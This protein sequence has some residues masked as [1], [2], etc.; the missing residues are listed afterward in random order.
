MSGTLNMGTNSINGIFSAQF[1]N[2]VTT[3]HTGDN[4]RRLIF[5]STEGFQFYESAGLGNRTGTGWATILDTNNYGSFLGLGNYWAQGGNSFSGIGILGTNDSYDLQ[6]ETAGTT[7][8]TI[9][10]SGNVGIG[11]TTPSAKL[12]IGG[13]SSVISN[14]IGN[15]TISPFSGLLTLNATIEA[16]TNNT[17]DVGTATNRMKDVY[18]QG[19][20][21]VGANGDSGKV[22]YN[23]T[24]D[25]L[26]FSNDGTNWIA[27]GDI[28]KSV[29]LSAEY[30]GAVMSADGT[31]NIGFMTSDAEGT[32]YDSMNYYEWYSSETTLQ[33]YDIRVRFTLPSDFAGWGTNAFTFNYATEANASTNNKVDFYIYEEGTGTVDGSSLGKYSV[34]AGVW[35]TTSV[36]GSGL[37]DCNVAGE[38]C[39][40][41]MR[42]YSANDNYVRV[43]DIDI[44]Y[45]REL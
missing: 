45:N 22:R 29:T 18:A 37:T 24:N 4:E 17:Y 31:D 13:S 20:I 39:V 2:S 12:D 3:S 32:T 7:K 26:E 19:N 43:G 42:M 33:D 5:D 16:G 11:T 41:I 30:A 44:N 36:A 40:V 15:I 38:T 10:T 23:T 8:M 1:S 9:D 14:T 6:F 35:T 34:T 21:E 27:L 28:D 25:Q